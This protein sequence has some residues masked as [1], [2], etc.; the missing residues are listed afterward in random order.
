MW[1]ADVYYT[2]PKGVRGVIINYA[3]KKVIP[4]LG[5][6]LGLYCDYAWLF[7]QLKVSDQG[8]FNEVCFPAWFYQNSEFSKSLTKNDSNKTKGLSALV[9]NSADPTNNFIELIDILHSTS[10]FKKFTFVLN[11]GGTTEYIT[12]VKEYAQEK[13]SHCELIFLTDKLDYIDYIQVVS[14]HDALLY[15]HAR[16]QG[17]G[18]LNIAFELGL[19]VFIPEENPMTDNYKNWHVKT[20]TTESLES[21]SIE[22]LEEKQYKLENRIII[23]G[24]YHPANVAKKLISIIK[25]D[26]KLAN[27]SSTNQ[28]L[29]IDKSCEK[30]AK[31]RR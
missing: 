28:C 12:K 25:G 6:K 30:V 31:R 4:K 2:P 29:I 7:K 22:K 14:E 13:L 27:N 20:F 24:Y 16:Q 3:R 19:A 5:H 18:S 17:V 11:Y 15:N 21:V 1:G 26:T 10:A 9:G 8:I 23:Q